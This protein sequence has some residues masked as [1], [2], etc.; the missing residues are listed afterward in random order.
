M[1]MAKGERDPIKL[2]NLQS[3]SDEA[4]RKVARFIRN[5]RSKTTK[6]KFT[7][8]Q[9]QEFERLGVFR[10]IESPHVQNI[11]LLKALMMAMGERD[12]V[13]LQQFTTSM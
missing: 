4:E 5:C 13:K 2:Q 11:Q 8:E 3:S 6:Y 9:W 10:I 1:M 12:P 7:E